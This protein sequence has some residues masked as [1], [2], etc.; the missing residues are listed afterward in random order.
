MR[1]ILDALGL[2]GPGEYGGE[3]MPTPG[4][5]VIKSPSGQEIPFDF[6]DISSQYDLKAA[7]FESAAGNG[8]YVQPNGHTSGRFPMAAIFH[9][10]GYEL[11][12]EAFLSAML[13][14]GVFVLTHP[15]YRI[16]INVVP[17][18]TVDRFDGYQSGTNQTIYSVTFFETTGLLVGG[19]SD[20]QQSFDSFLDASAADF[21]DAIDTDSVLDEKSLL[22][23]VKSTVKTIQ[24][25]L[26]RGSQGLENAT[27]GIEA[28]GDSINRGIDTL[29][30]QPLTMARQMQI[31]IGE[32]ARQA[33]LSKSK[34]TAYGD[35][36][37]SIFGMPDAEQN[38]YSRETINAFHTNALVA[39][40][41]VANMA[42]LSVKGSGEFETKFDFLYWAD[43]LKSK[44]DDLQEWSDNNFQNIE[45]L[46]AIDRGA[47]DVGGGLT[48]LWD[49]VAK[50][51]SDLI[52]GSF[53]AKTQFSRELAAEMTPIDLCYELY[54]TADHDHLDLLARTNDL[55]GDEYFL[56][57]KGR[58]I[59][60][61]L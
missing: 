18:G 59:V 29:I 40:T 27:R 47:I 50:A 54:G 28:V 58:R 5:A 56:I 9:G 38:K 3:P 41:T 10:S 8:T 32:P 23:R 37:D 39:K 13:E 35:M 11:R 25:A 6:E 53:E 2:L 31:L 42:I 20:I 49:T 33:D 45:D 4:K 7:V 48:D 55:S 52:T 46:T 17:V 34:L 44:M 51:I 19:E 30:G 36:A 21:A 24:T 1:F 26:K 61:Y 60:W 12:A 15:Q 43:Y 22:E 14:S 57:P 16:P